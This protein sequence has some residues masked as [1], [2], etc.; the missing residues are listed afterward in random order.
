[1]AHVAIGMIGLD[2]AAGEGAEERRAAAF[3]VEAAATPQTLA[4]LINIFAQRSLTP[5][6]VTACVSEERLQVRIEQPA[7]TAREAGLLAERLRAAVLVSRVAV[8]TG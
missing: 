7:L 5:T 1:M 8:E 2:K 6:L 4:R 3:A